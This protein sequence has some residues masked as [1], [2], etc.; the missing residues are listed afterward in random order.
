MELEKKSRNKKKQHLFYL[1]KKR[2]REGTF[3]SEGRVPAN[4]RF[5]NYG[6]IFSQNLRI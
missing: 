3:F 5:I 2:I 4:K 6:R 1:K